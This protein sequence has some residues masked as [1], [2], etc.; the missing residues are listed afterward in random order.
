M[1][2]VLELTI[3]KFHNDL[4]N[5]KTTCKEV[6]Q[7]YIDRINEYD[8]KNDKINA[9][10]LINNK[11]LMEAEECDKK[12]ANDKSVI[13]KYPLFGCPLLVKDNYE[14][15]DMPTTAG[16]KT[17]EGFNTKKDAFAVSLLRKAGAIIIAKTNLHEFAVWGENVSSILGQTHNPYDHSRSSGGSSGGTGAGIAANFGLIGIGTDT[18][19]SV[20]SPSS[21][22]SICGIRPTIGLVSRM[23]IVPYSLTQDTGGSLC[24][25]LEDAVKTF[26]VM[27]GVDK[28]DPVTIEG[29]K[30]KENDYTIHLK[31]DGLKGKR[32]GI[33]RS[34]MGK[35]DVHQEV[36]RCMEKCFEALR[37]NGAE[38]ID[39]EET[40]DIGHLVNDISLHLW[41]F[42]YELEKYLK[43]HNAKYQTFDELI[44][45][46]LCT[47]DIISNLEEAN[48]IDINSPEY[49]KRAE[50]R[51]ELIE[52]V[53]KLFNKYKID[54]I[55]YPHQQQLVCKV[56]AKQAERNGAIG[57]VTGFP[58]IVVPGGFST[59][60][61]NAPI[62]VPVGME[63]L[64]L[65]YTEG[66]LIE[67]AYGFEQ[68]T[69]YRKLPILGNKN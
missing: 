38:L 22:N 6:V 34:F 64:G 33:L 47:P 43:E 25:T 2:D 30:H 57:S 65:P 56:G 42:K 29:N 39:I 69:K 24:R 48:K 13:D 11:A 53:K 31:V 55:V 60:D 66:K 58:A 23:G 41:D 9:I 32:I 4:K 5:G 3:E 54:A 35:K 59:N 62:G 19:N 1:Y 15:Y 63:I 36:N 68:A 44:S 26:E 10:I 67:I 28:E 20:R 7:S 17:L 45:S 12:I 51:L 61:D 14:T 37:K 52:D 8:K 27:I 50:K 40:F 46:G 21:A 49:K 18:I 16:S